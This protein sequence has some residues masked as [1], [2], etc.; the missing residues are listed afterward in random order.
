MAAH[1]AGQA[2]RSVSFILALSRE[3][4]AFHMIGLP[5]CL[6]MS[7]YRR[8]EHFT[9]EMIVAP[10]IALE[11]VAGKQHQQLIAPENIALLVHGADAVG[12][13]VVGDAQIGFLLFHLVDQ[14]ARD[15]PA[16]SDRDDGTGNLPSGAQAISQTWHPS[17]RKIGGATGPPTPLPASMTTFNGRESLRHIGEQM[18]GDTAGRF[19]SVRP[20]RPVVRGNRS[21]SIGGA[22]VLD[23]FAVERVFAQTNFKA[24]ILRR[25]VARGNF[26]AAVDVEMKQAK[27]KA[28]ASGKRRYRR[29]AGR[30]TTMPAITASA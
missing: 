5:P 18:L 14:H 15:F 19:R 29:R 7:S 9:S 28:A 27:N 16:P 21:R 13:A 24:I 2:A 4:P 10:G 25:I 23:L 22:D 6:A 8:C 20:C 11:H 12:V 26:N 1:L 30:P 17:W 3:W